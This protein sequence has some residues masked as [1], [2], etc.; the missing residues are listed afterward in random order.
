[1]N[2]EKKRRRKKRKFINK[3]KYMQKT[4]KKKRM[5]TSNG[6]ALDQ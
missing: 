4:A 6:Q 5:R 2:L 3:A 1:M